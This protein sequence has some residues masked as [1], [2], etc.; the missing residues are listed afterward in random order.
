MR[1]NGQMK[2]DQIAMSGASPFESIPGHYRLPLACRHM[3]DL[4]VHGE[5]LLAPA[6]APPQ[7]SGA[8]RISDDVVAAAVEAR[9][10]WMTR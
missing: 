6:D 7:A 2:S 5:I 3:V 10:G 4:L 9:T 8:V 1:Q